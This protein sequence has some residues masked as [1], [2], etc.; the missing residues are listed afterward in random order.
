MLSTTAA[1][2]PTPPPPPQPPIATGS[3][4]LE[5]PKGEEKE[6]RSRGKPRADRREG[7]AQG[8]TFLE[9][10]WGGEQERASSILPPHPSLLLSRPLRCIAFFR[11][12]SRRGQKP[13][14]SPERFGRVTGAPASRYL[15]AG[16]GVCV[17]ACQSANAGQSLPV[18]SL[19]PSHSRL[20]YL[21]QF[22]VSVSS[23]A[24]AVW[25]AA[26]SGC[27]CLKALRLGQRAGRSQREQGRGA[28]RAKSF[29]VLTKAKGEQRWPATGKFGND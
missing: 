4:S 7:R 29:G 12:G 11:S 27:V 8:W 6:K 16:A 28:G 9:L 19:S 26:C 20:S 18:S 5:P 23:R 22:P 3:S 24:L 15:A 14:S 13:L 25:Y 17:C 1:V 10:E 21:C 2:S